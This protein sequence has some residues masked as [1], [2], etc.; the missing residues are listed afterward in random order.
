MNIMKVITSERRE[1]SKTKESNSTGNET[2]KRVKIRYNIILSAVESKCHHRP[3]P[4]RHFVSCCQYRIASQSLLDH[5]E[6]MNLP[7][8]YLH[9]S[10]LHS[11]SPT[12]L[13]ILNS[14]LLL[15]WGYSGA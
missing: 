8:R 2:S 6:E 14:F 15:L 5:I 13:R 7:H 11:G 10:S 1:N 3:R 4:R 12:A 9:R